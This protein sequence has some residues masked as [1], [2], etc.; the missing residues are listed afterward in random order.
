MDRQ[1]VT[2]ELMKMGFSVSNKGFEYMVDAIEMIHEED[3]DVKFTV[4]YAQIAR[5][6]KKD[7][8]AVERCIRW[9]VESYYK[10]CESHP[11]LK[12]DNTKSGMYPS[13][14]VLA[15]LY[16]IFYKPELLCEGE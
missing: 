5:K 7:Q 16:L 11:Y 3:G 15:R 1:G 10:A 8:R 9:E 14:E 6:H 13:K 12:A 4:L 2:R